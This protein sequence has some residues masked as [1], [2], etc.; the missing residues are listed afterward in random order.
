MNKLATISASILLATAGLTAFAVDAADR[1]GWGQWANDPYALEPSINGWVSASGEYP[2]QA[3]EDAALAA[4]G[5]AGTDQAGWGEWAN[6]PHAL[7]PA[8]NGGVSCRKAKR[9]K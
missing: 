2:T 1:S 6:D 7:E 8:I 4:Q 9:L 3:L 5:S